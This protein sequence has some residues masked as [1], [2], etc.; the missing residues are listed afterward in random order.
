[1]SSTTRHYQRRRY[2]ALSCGQWQPWANPKPVRAH[3]RHLRHQGGTYAAIARAAG[4]SAMTIHAIANGQGRIKPAIATALLAISIDDLQRPRVHA[5]GTRLRLRSLMAMGHDCTRIARAAGA[6]PAVIRKLAQGR[7]ADVTPDLQERI[8]N[9]WEAWWDKTPPQ[10]TPAERAAATS[11]RATA[12]R[13]N[14]CTP[15]G[16]D[17]DL[18][19]CI[20]YQ[21]SH[22]WLPA[23]GT[24]TAPDLAPPHRGQGTTAALPHTSSSEEGTTMPFDPVP[25]PASEYQ[26]G[27]AFAHQMFMRQLDAGIGADQ[28]AARHDAAVTTLTGAARNDSEHE[29]LRGFTATSAD[30]LATLRDLQQAEASQRQQEHDQEREAG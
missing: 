10:R 27:A 6:S 12:R 3:V 2:Q 21:P 24:G 16:L 18:I 29:F 5:G 23:T 19:D 9:I 13:H 17:E 25:R 28:I 14:W 26:K 7:A 4:V 22:G 20:G 1:M 30:H 11:A 15:L 8:Q